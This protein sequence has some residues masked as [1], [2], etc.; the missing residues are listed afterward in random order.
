MSSTFFHTISWGEIIDLLFHTLLSLNF[1]TLRDNIESCLQVTING[2]QIFVESFHQKMM[3]LIYTCVCTCV[4]VHKC[5]YVYMCAYIHMY[6]VYL[7]IELIS[8]CQPLSSIH[9]LWLL[10]KLLR[11]WKHI[12]VY[13]KLSLLMLTCFLS[14]NFCCNEQKCTQRSL[15]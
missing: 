5:I 1:R 2:F 3:V 15:R 11:I 14:G 9:C 10:W 6:C 13:I 12:Y 7:Y 8:W 4:C